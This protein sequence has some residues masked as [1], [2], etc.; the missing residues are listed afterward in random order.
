MKSKRTAQ[1]TPKADYEYTLRQIGQY[2]RD[3]RQSRGED[4]YDV[5]EFLRI[6]PAYLFAIE[7]GDLDSTPGS[8]YAIGFI[9]SY[10]NYLGADT[11]SVV[12]KARYALSGLDGTPVE[13]SRK[14]ETSAEPASRYPATRIVALSA[15]AAVAMIVAWQVQK[16]DVVLPTNLAELPTNIQQ[17]VAG[18]FGAAGDAAGNGGAETANQQQT[19]ANNANSRPATP[20]AAI[21]PQLQSDSD[22]A[23]LSQPEAPAPEPPI[24]RIDSSSAVAAE[25]SGLDGLNEQSEQNQAAPSALELLAALQ[26]RDGDSARVNQPSSAA[27]AENRVVLVALEETWIQVRSA[28]RDYVRTRTLLPGERMAMP[29]REDLSL[30]TGNAGGLQILLDG[31]VLGQPGA[32]QQ[33]IKDLSLAPAALQEQLGGQ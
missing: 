19:A 1:A 11:K 10:A 14:Q 30:W 33:V 15:A 21:L 13:P 18:Y 31:E 17:S 9:R 32:A 4:L 24:T 23:A 16:S 25:T 5:A 28:S 29:D 3:H 26:A 6:K 27:S 12:D 2:L 8:T 22:I 20:S 7:D